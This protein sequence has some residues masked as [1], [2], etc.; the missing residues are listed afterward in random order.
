MVLG[1]DLG[2]TYSV[3]AYVDESGMLQIIN[4]SEGS[5]ITPSVVMFDEKS[6]IVVGD[7]AK[8]NAVIRPQDVVS[9]VKNYMGKQMV[10]KEY[11]NQKYTPEM[12]SSFIIRKIVK[13]AE[14]YSGKQVTGVVI[15]V[16]AYFTDAQRKATEDA[17]SMAGVSL[18][19]MINEPTAAALCY[20]KKQNIQNENI[21]IYDLG[22]GTFD[23][24]ILRVESG[25][26][27]DV[28]ATGGLSNAG[29]R[30]FDQNIVDY[31]VEY[32][33]EKY[34]IDLED[35]EYLD[36]LQEIYQ[37]A[38]SAKMQLS[39]RNTTSI[40]LKIGK[41]KEQIEITREQFNSMISKV[42]G[43][44]ENK[45]K[46]AVRAAGVSFS[47][48][49]KILL[50]GGSSRIPYIIENIQKCIGKEISREVNPDEAVALGAALYAE[51]NVNE[52]ATASFTDVCS[53][54]IGIVVQN[55][56]GQEENEVV[57]PRNS[58]LPVSKEQRFRTIVERQSVIHLTI[59]EGEYKELTDITIIG[60]F[61][62]NLPSGLPENALVIITISLDKYQLIHI[63]I[64]LPDANFEEEHRMKRIANMDE[65]MVKN[66]TGILRD[67]SVQ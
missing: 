51:M 4:N 48:I 52:S 21:L 59:T 18:V 7:I 12:I 53:H 25:N 32:I 11:E 42:Y 56:K 29:G 23:V 55:N 39:T 50:V 38:E 3:G 14:E 60:E 62:I 35:D 10:L 19:G 27:I 65:E 67:Y 61:D 46:E 1:I 43:R 54:S 15:T 22:G 28:L 40:V 17:A 49:D 8:D 44:T 45:M 2:T 13:D 33:N 26:K 24:T 64:K 47:E 34:E 9:V 16:P 30:F 37:K 36:D 57:I 66:V 6:H 58:K 5:T 41:I 31:I 20:I 63:H